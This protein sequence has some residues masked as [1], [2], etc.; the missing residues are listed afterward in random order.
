[1]SNHQTTRSNLPVLAKLFAD[2]RKI[3]LAKY[4]GVQRQRIEEIVVRYP[5]IDGDAVVGFGVE[6]QRGV[7]RHLD[8]LLQGIRTNEAGVAGE[9]TLELAKNIKAMNLPRLKREAAG[10]DWFGS[11]IGQLPVVGKWASALRYFQLTNR[12]IVKHLA[13]IE[14]KAQ[15]E[16]AKL[17]GTNIKLD[18]LAEKTI[19]ALQEF[20]LHLAAGQAILMRGRGEFERCKESAARSDDI[21]A[22]TRLR[23]QA[24]LINAFEARLLRIHVAYT[25]AFVSV[26]QIRLTQQ[27]ARIE[28]H[29]IMDT[30][31]FDIPRL[32][33]AILRVAA[34]NQINQASKANDARRAV[35]RQVG[36]I[37]ADA[38]EQAYLKAKESQGNWVED[39]ALLAATADKLLETIAKGAALSEDNRRKHE[40]AHAQLAGIRS[41]FSEGLDAA[42]LE[43]IRH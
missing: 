33:S 1:M 26:P 17:T 8:E 36:A 40:Q 12:E 27:A 41:K 24:E 43:F 19:E 22:V 2:E 37:G 13:E 11:T 39:I 21:I 38:L 9:L 16:M 3:N 31:Q 14:S 28:I 25:D 35:T 10:Q 34:L 4:E 42:A 6:P 32:K 7:N 5:V 20:E 29:N 18:K 23:D 30:V 15:R